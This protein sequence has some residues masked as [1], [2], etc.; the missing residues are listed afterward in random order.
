MS[1]EVLV[2]ISAATTRQNDELF[3]S[4]ANAYIEF[5]PHRTHSKG[6]LRNRTRELQA[7]EWQPKQS[8]SRTRIDTTTG[9]ADPV[10]P[11]ASEEPSGSFP[12]IVPADGYYP[13]HLDSVRSTSRLA[14]LDRSY[15]S[16]R[17]RAT[18]RPSF[19]H[20]GPEKRVCS[21]GFDTDTGFI[22]D[23]QTALQALQSQLQDT[24]AA[25][26]ANTSGDEDGED[27]PI[28]RPHSPPNYAI[29]PARTQES[30]KSAERRL[31]VPLAET[32][33]NDVDVRMPYKL[34]DLLDPSSL[35]VYDSS[36]DTAVETDFLELPADAFPPPPIIS[37]A[38]PGILPS[39]ITKHLAAIKATN[40]T[41]FRPRKVRRTLEHDE[42]GS[43]HMGCK[44][45][46]STAQRDFWLSLC[47]HVSSGRV[48][49][50]TTIHRE[51]GSH[52][53]LGLVRL[54]CWGEAVEHMWLLLWLCSKGRVSG[55][56]LQW[57]DASGIA[58]VEMA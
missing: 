32:T 12:S 13:E 55:L 52:G 56:G 38:R 35:E 39:Q 16:W 44:R 42:R 31:S 45:W 53:D 41:R 2:H 7:S 25:T 49:W 40:S 6:S 43:W 33:L 5:E 22:E 15:L 23:S 11:T 10:A 24:Y 17:K 30:E 29:N 1:D 4:L 21:D 37:V 58:V 54:Y 19:A 34:T 14:Q 36:E 18:P 51:A 20:S 9:V 48:G 3:R 28:A 46:S 47:E 26:S 50:A 57:I 8:S 27:D